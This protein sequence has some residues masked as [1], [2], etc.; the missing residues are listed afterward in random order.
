MSKETSA[1][2][3]FNFESNQVRTLTLNDEPWF[4]AADVCKALNC[5]PE[6]TRRLDDDEKGLH[7]VQTLG[8]QQE[9]IIINESGLYSLILTSRKPQAKTFKRWVTH[10]VL[11]AIRK[12]GQYSLA[13]VN[14][15]RTTTHG[16]GRYAALMAELERLWN[17]SPQP[18]SESK[19]LPLAM[20][21]VPATATLLR[22]QIWIDLVADLDKPDNSRL[23]WRALVAILQA[24]AQMEMPAHTH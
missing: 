3:V 18:G 20:Q 1:L 23:K 13:P 21:G 14:A 10:E 9:V 7:I 17:E 24:L 16:W 22:N 8:G 15:L 19:D 6:Q 11:P 5:Q 2:Q 4:V 12:T